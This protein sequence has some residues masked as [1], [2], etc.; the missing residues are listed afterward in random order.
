M[1]EG[2]TAIGVDGDGVVSLLG[3]G[4]TVVHA[5]VH[6]TSNAY[7]DSHAYV[8]VTVLPK[9][10]TATTQSAT[11]VYDGTSLTADG[12][13]KELVGGDVFK[14]IGMQTNAGSSTN[15]YTITKEGTDVSAMANYNI[16]ESLGTLKVTRKPTTADLKLSQSGSSATATATIDGFLSEEDASGTVQF[17]IKDTKVGN[18]VSIAKGEG[19]AHSASMS[20][21]DVPANNYTI[22]AIFTPS[23]ANSKYLPST[24][25]ATGYK[26]PAQRAIN[27]TRL[28]QKTY[29]GEG[30]S[31]DLSL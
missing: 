20:F 29:G 8:V 18:P 14:T 3:V 13:C 28:Y 11:K 17:Y 19:G 22:T 25:T 2:T 16:T 6:D 26:D 21:D 30:F 1:P 27:G 15:M 24:A 10:V 5:T 31:L 7:A 23:G 12:T 4:T 9:S